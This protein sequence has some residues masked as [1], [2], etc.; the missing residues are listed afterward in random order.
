MTRQC[1]Q[2]IFLG[3]RPNPSQVAV[4]LTC[5]VCQKSICLLPAGRN[6]LSRRWVYFFSVL[7]SLF[8]AKG[9]DRPSLIALH[10]Q[11]RGPGFVRPR[12]SNAELWVV[13]R[14]PI[15]ESGWS[16]GTPLQSL[17]GHTVPH[18]RVWVV[19]RYPIAESGWSYGTPSR[20]SR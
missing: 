7:I 10:S 19:I 20:R 8:Q 6:L 9:L 12:Y 1:L 5:G 15:A 11:Q 18:C 13:I 14:Y 17:G 2:S 16:Y 4:Q 3:V